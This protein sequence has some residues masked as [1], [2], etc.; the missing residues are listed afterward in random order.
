MVGCLTGDNDVQGSATD[1]FGV[2]VTDLS[3]LELIVGLFVI[4]EP[5]KESELETGIGRLLTPCCPPSFSG[6]CSG[7]CIM[8]PPL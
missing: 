4:A 6:R 8:E 5:E 2:K 1:L 3:K 7:H